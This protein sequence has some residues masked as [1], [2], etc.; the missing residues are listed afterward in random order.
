MDKVSIRN[1]F[2]SICYGEASFFLSY[3]RIELFFDVDIKFSKKNS[4][5]FSYPPDEN[6]KPME[7]LQIKQ[8]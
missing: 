5:D 8:T 4:H 6:N 1:S 2:V 7:T 3:I